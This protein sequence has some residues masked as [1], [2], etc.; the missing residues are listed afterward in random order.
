MSMPSNGVK[1]TWTTW[2]ERHVQ[3]FFTGEATHRAVIST[4][5]NMQYIIMYMWHLK[6]IYIICNVFTFIYLYMNI[7]MISHVF[8]RI[9]FTPFPVRSVKSASSPARNQGRLALK[10]LKDPHGPAAVTEFWAARC[11]NISC[12]FGLSGFIPH[13]T[14]SMIPEM[15]MFQ[16]KSDWAIQMSDFLKKRS[17]GQFDMLFLRPFAMPWWRGGGCTQFLAFM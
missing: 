15:K 8:T 10:R 1:G 4:S 6:K 11:G 16:G 9:L 5:R 12:C 2:H 7:Y 14:Q 13:V 17:Q 3:Q